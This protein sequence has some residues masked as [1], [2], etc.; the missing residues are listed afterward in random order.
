MTEAEWLA[1]ADPQPMLEFVRGKASDRKLRLFGVACCRRGLHL[2]TDERILSAVVS[3]ERYAD[4]QVT[5]EEQAAMNETAQA[6][7]AAAA[8]TYRNQLVAEHLLVT[9]NVPYDWKQH[10]PLACS[11]H[12]LS[13][14]VSLISA[15]GRSLDLGQVAHKVSYAVAQAWQ[16]DGSIATDPD[17]AGVRAAEE[18][19]RIEETELHAQCTLVRDIFGN[20]LHSPIANPSWLTSTVTNL[21]QAIYTDRAFDRMPILADA[22]EDAGCTNQDI[23]AHCRQPGEHV[24]GCWVVDLLLG[25]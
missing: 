21:A 24:R 5:D 19:D 22:L 1:C 13:D 14:A 8:T 15:A 3:A 9:Q 4:S 2:L 17:D 23:L 25:K 20:P 7:T 10:D 11:R 12:C 18:M 16:D 6:A